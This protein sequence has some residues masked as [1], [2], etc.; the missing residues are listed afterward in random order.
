LYISFTFKKNYQTLLPIELMLRIILSIM[1]CSLLLQAAKAEKRD[2]LIGYFKNSGRKVTSKDSADYYRIIL[3][4]DTNID[5]DLYRVYEYYHNGKL[6]RVATSL[7]GA[8]NLVLDGTCIEYFLNGKR[9]GIAQYKN[10]IPVDNVTHYYPNGNLY[11]ILK[12]EDLNSGYYDRYFHGY[13]TGNGYNYKV[14][15]VQLR[16]SV[17][18]LLAVNGTGHVIVFDDDFKNV[19]EEGDL[20]NDKKEGEWRGL[21]NDSGKFVCVFHRDVLKSGTS[22][23]KSGN[24]YT[25][26]KVN[27][28]PVF[29]D[30]VDAFYLFIKKNL[31]YPES[32]K[33]H[34]VAGTVWVGFYV[35]INGTVSDVNVIEGLTKSVDDEALRVISLS[36]LWIPGYKFGIPVRTHYRVPVSFYN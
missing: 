29:S 19:L 10:G 32:A 22:Y 17:G 25:F 3:P 15:V 11:D 31:Q 27:V 26:K 4:P 8:I 12:I 20:K 30:G 34:K 24:R 13:F 1:I 33:K 23:M 36:P 18:N 28:D 35:E 2:S 14:Q 21:V 16:D 9:K 7:T 6:K 5:K